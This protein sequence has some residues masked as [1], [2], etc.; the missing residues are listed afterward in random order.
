LLFLNNL[1]EFLAH[2]QPE[3]WIC[4]G[5]FNEIMTDSEKWGG[6]RRQRRLMEDFR[7][8]A[9]ECAIADLGF[10]GPKFTWA[11]D[12][13]GI[14]FIKER[15][16][17]GLV[18]QSWRDLYP[19]AEIRVEAAVFSNHSL[20]NLCLVNRT[21]GGHKR[22]YFRYEANWALEVDSLSVVSKAWNQ[23][24][25][26]NEWWP[27]LEAK[28]KTCKR[29]LLAWQ[30][31]KTQPA[32]RTIQALQE[33]LGDLQGQE[34]N[35]ENGEMKQIRDELQ[36]LLDKENI[37]WQQRAKTDW[38]KFGDRNTKI[39]HACANARRQGNFI[40]SIYDES[41]CKW[42]STKGI[43]EAFVKYFTSLFTAGPE[44]DMGPCL[45]HVPR[46]VTNEM[47]DEL[48]KEFTADEIH[49]ALTQMAPLKAPGPDGL[50]ACFYQT[51]WMTLGTE[52]CEFILS[53]LNS[54]VIPTELNMTHIALVPEKKQPPKCHRIST[55]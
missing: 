53:I 13:E 35:G 51:H 32:S 48:I 38:L 50:N 22:D 42:E 29:D 47:N 54:G 45:Q 34:G 39:Y 4:I 41:G 40:H 14:A 36:L 15:L 37:H 52:V 20:L 27:R 9:E 49:A 7:N 44:R 11:N 1:R 26:R 25:R 43:N 24:I 23:P 18:N 12:R 28:L 30:K 6:N 8:T 3:P 31:S 2:I 5:D 21:G 10:R 17:R 55:H 46:R 19:G 33:R 16:D